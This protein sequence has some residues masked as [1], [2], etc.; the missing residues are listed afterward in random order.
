MSTHRDA[1]LPL[2]DESAREAL[3]RILE[4]HA[5]PSDYEAF[6]ARARRD[7]A[8]WDDL[9]AGLRDDDALRLALDEELEPALHVPLPA[10]R[11]SAGGLRAWGGW[12]AAAA[13]ALLW[14]TAELT[15]PAPV[16]PGWT[17]PVA[18]GPRATDARSGV[19]VPDPVLAELPS[20]LLG[21]RPAADGAG[22]EVL[23]LQPVLRR[24]RVANVLGVGSDELGRPATVPVDPA[25]LAHHE[26]F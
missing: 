23:Y 9:L 16:S 22:Y 4:R 17:P 12:L 18:E 14:A 1:Q 10:P 20:R 21:T 2:P 3:D 25:V 19:P 26:T 13:M 8:C 11:A 24:A 5:L 15:P 7:P 6:A